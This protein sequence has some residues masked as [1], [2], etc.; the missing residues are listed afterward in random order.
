MEC[1]GLIGSPPFFLSRRDTGI[2][3]APQGC[4]PGAP[5][6]TSDFLRE[7]YSFPTA[8]LTQRLWRCT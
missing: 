7:N 5:R 2:S 6:V 4:N 8:P 3:H 1:F